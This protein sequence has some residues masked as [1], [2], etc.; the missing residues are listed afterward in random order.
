MFFYK[1][2]VVLVRQG[3]KEFLVL[4]LED[5]FNSFGSTSDNIKCEDVEIYSDNGWNKL[6]C[7]KRVAKDKWTINQAYTGNI[8]TATSRNKYK[9]LNKSKD[10]QLQLI[11][12]D[13][14]SEELLWILGYSF[15]Q[16]KDNK[17]I[18][19]KSS[20]SSLYFAIKAYL[21]LAFQEVSFSEKAFKSDLDEFPYIG[22][23]TLGDINVKKYLE[24]SYFLSES[25]FPNFFVTSH[26]KVGLKSL[27]A[28]IIDANFTIKDYSWR[29]GYLSIAF[30]KKMFWLF[31]YLGL[32]S[33]IINRTSSKMEVKIKY[34][35]DLKMKLYNKD[36]L[37]LT[38]KKQSMVLSNKIYRYTKFDEYSY[39]YSLDCK[40]PNINIS[41]LNINLV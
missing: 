19:R 3:F 39:G 13:L 32:T 18:S 2:E 21:N 10:S 26:T 27:L 1:D 11:Q 9:V 20:S 4:T 14:F 35:D 41:N 8:I 23:F 17:V 28:G 29:S 30:A 25:F 15:M 12:S 16:N 37:S 40:E 22:E 36:L 33:Y 7:I 24:D 34:D 31:N 38:S 5:L 6:N